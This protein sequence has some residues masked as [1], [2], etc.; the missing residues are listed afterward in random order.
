MGSAGSRIS[1]SKTVQH[2][3]WP[4]L[5]VEA[6]CDDMNNKGPHPCPYYLWFDGVSYQDESEKPPP[7]A[8]VG[9]S[10]NAAHAPATAVPVRTPP[11]PTLQPADFAA[12][13]AAAL[14]REDPRGVLSRMPPSAETAT[15]KAYQPPPGLTVNGWRVI[16]VYYRLQ[17]L[18]TGGYMHVLTTFVNAPPA[19][20][21]AWARTQPKINLPAVA[22]DSV[23]EGSEL[24]RYTAAGGIPLQMPAVEYIDS[25][26]MTYELADR[27]GEV[28]RVV[29]DSG[30]TGMISCG[31]IDASA[32]QGAAE[33]SRLGAVTRVA[34]APDLPQDFVSGGFRISKSAPGGCKGLYEG[35]VDFNAAMIRDDWNT[36]ARKAIIL[37]CKAD[38]TYFLQG[39][40]AEAIGRPDTAGSYYREAA[41][42]AGTPTLRFSEQCALNRPRGGSGSNGCLGSTSRP[43]PRRRN[44]GSP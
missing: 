10:R 7:R 15:V 41:R 40:S 32:L 19:Q 18:Q 8:D 39:R 35:G 20:V 6:V 22:G 3:R 21:L 36:V 44:S 37:G 12:F 24:A 30:S 13:E 38:I 16:G 17:G 25:P 2:N 11:R 26:V 1:V 42:L 34:A 4:D 9:P 33:P 27:T 29:A 5:R 43:R 28:Q 31:Q 23:P 14:C